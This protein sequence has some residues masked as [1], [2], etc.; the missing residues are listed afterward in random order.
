MIRLKWTASKCRICGTTSLSS[1]TLTSSTPSATL[2]CISLWYSSMRLNLRQLLKTSTSCQ[3]SPEA[4]TAKTHLD[5]SRPNI[6]SQKRTRKKVK[7]IIFACFPRKKTQT[8]R[9]FLY[10]RIKSKRTLSL[11][12]TSH[13]INPIRSSSSTIKS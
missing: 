9:S 7:S 2:S 8:K 6:F 1:T 4:K 11:K 12:S 10:C 3:C 5:Y 13:L